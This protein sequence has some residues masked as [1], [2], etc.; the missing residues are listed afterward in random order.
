M[1]ILKDPMIHMASLQRR[2]QA[3]SLQRRAQKREEEEDNEE[4][5]AE[6]V[7]ARQ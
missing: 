5:E 6:G 7:L 3:V 4:G 2:I 1:I